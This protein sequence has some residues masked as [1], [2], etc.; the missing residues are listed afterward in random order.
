[1]SRTQYLHVCPILIEI[2]EKTLYQESQCFLCAS[3]YLP[4]LGS[5]DGEGA[6]GW[7]VFGLGLHTAGIT[8]V[9]GLCQAKAAQD[10]S[11]S[12]KTNGNT[13]GQS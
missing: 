4:G 3:V 2:F 12:C 6:T 1:M 5:T 9:V 7:V 8:A 11:T 13:G 10:F